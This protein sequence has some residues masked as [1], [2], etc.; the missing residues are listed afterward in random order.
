MPNGTI[1]SLTSVTD[2]ITHNANY[3]VW[4]FHLKPL[5]WSNGAN[6]TA[7]DVLAS[8]SPKFYFNTTYDVLGMGPEV[9]RTYAVNSSTAAFVLNSPDAMWANKMSV[10]SVGFTIFPK[11]IVDQYGPAYPNLGTDV[12]LGPFYISNYTAGSFTMT[13]LRNPYYKPQPTVCKI[14]INFVE[15]VSQTTESLLAGTSDWAQIEPSN[16]PSILKDPNLHLFAEPAMETTTLEYNDTVYP[17]NMTEF[18]QALVYGIN[19]SQLIQQA[20]DGYGYTAY[21][22]MGLVP[23]AGNSIWYTPN[24]M[25]YDYNV[26]QALNLLNSIGMKK[27][28]DGNLQYPNGTAVTINLWAPTDTT[29]DTIGSNVL[30]SNLAK[31]G[32]TV[33]VQS[34]SIASIIGDLASNVG[35]IARTGVIL[36]TSTADDFGFVLDNVLPGPAIYEI[37]PVSGYTWEWP[38]FVQNE[39]QSN[40]SAIDLT[41]NQSLLQKYSYNIEA[42]NAQYL[43]TIVLAYPDELYA[44]STQRFTGWVTTPN[45]FV[46][47]STTLNPRALLTLVPVSLSGQTSTV[48]NSSTAAA[49]S[50]SA[51]LS[52]AQTT[53]SSSSTSLSLNAVAA[54]VAIVVVIS[55][56]MGAMMRRR[57]SS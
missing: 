45:N 50:N 16:A 43:P 8:F 13:M 55:A 14:E 19:Q 33:N 46:Y 6:V 4:M 28:S 7:D 54:V 15:S 29:V 39:Y 22:S 18:R 5:V 52:S 40:I 23:S 10:P 3:T 44:Y 51:T 9:N 37:A 21:D 42:L 57:R 34:V 25:K 17:Y 36:F 11:S 24:I 2:V 53:S 48:S 32:I 35:N 38:Q 49:A 47:G 31:L 41:D 27:G 26:S 1:D 20:F 30:V 56:A 12:V